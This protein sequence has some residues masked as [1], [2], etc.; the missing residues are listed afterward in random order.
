[1]KNNMEDIENKLVDYLH[2]ELDAADKQVL[3]ALLDADADLYAVYARF[4]QTISTPDEAVMFPDKS[5]LLKSEPQTI[6]RLR[7]WKTWAVAA[8]IYPWYVF[9]FLKHCRRIQWMST[10]RRMLQPTN[11]LLPVSQTLLAMATGNKLTLQL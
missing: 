9:L 8:A 2:G 4:A 1:M 6:T 7:N 3:E 11:K 5:K 10:Y